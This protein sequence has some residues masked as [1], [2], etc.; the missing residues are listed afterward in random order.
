MKFKIFNVYD[1]KTE[2]WDIPFYQRF[3]ADALREWSEH[4]SQ[5]DNP[6]NKIAK[7][8]S[9]FTLFEIGEYDQSIGEIKMYDVKFSHGTA[10]EHLKENIVS[11]N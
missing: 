5:K 6:K 10:L 4:A 7:Y 2:S 3:A 9:D 11:Q 1:S 8:P